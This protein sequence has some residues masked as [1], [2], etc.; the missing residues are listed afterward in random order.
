M[1]SAE[2]RRGKH[3]GSLSCGKP[4]R[5]Q[6]SGYLFLALL[7]L[8]GMPAAR[9]EYGDMGCTG[10]TSETCSPCCSGAGGVMPPPPLLDA[11]MDTSLPGAFAQRGRLDQP[12]H[13]PGMLAGKREGDSVLT[14]RGHLLPQV[15][16]GPHLV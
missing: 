4:S 3:P 5:A 9:G 11:L 12:S 15:T 13:L 8:L 6:G 16:V 2:P 7:G 10:R 1:K 14:Q